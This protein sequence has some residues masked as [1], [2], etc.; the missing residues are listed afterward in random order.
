MWLQYNRRIILG[1]HF[2]SYF[3]TFKPV[4]GMAGINS[5]D[6]NSSLGYNMMRNKQGK[7]N[8][9]IEKNGKMSW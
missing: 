3:V 1:K 4:A 7:L 6:N 2:S 5:N 8:G 9:I